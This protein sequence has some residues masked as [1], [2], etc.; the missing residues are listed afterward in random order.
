MSPKTK[1]PNSLHLYI[2]LN[3]RLSEIQKEF[4]THFPFLKIEFFK[5]PHKIGQGLKKD[6]IINANKLVKDCSTIKKGGVIEF[7]TVTPVS[8]LE[9]KF[10]KDFKL[11]VQVFRKAGSVWLETTATDN[12][13][14]AQQNEEGAEFSTP[15]K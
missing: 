7:T 15:S 13:T 5:V 11:S 12:W 2:D 8:D 14:L 3:S 10:F 6:L 9:T 1:T 4:N